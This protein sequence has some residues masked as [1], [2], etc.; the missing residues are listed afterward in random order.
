MAQQILTQVLQA[1]L[2]VVA[3]LVTLLA[4]LIKVTLDG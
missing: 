1:G 4:V 2:P 3:I